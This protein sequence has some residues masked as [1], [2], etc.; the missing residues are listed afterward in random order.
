MPI[1]FHAEHIDHGILLSK[2]ETPEEAE[3]VRN[4]FHERGTPSVISQ[5]SIPGDSKV[6]LPGPTK[7]Q[8]AKLIEG[9]NVELIP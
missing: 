6:Y 2:I 7:D 5:L 9:A 8:F 4:F 3:S 1:R